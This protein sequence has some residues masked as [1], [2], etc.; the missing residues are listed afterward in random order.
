MK[1]SGQ[2][3]MIGQD[4]KEEILTDFKIF[5]KDCISYYFS[6]TKIELFFMLEFYKSGYI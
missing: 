1:L 5:F 4:L 3:N 6:V 2:N